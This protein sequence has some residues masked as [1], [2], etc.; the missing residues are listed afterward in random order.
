[1]GKIL[2]IRGGAIGDFILTLPVLSALRQ[3]FPAVRLELLTYPRVAGLAV[4]GRLVEHAQSIEARALASFFARRGTLPEHLGAYFESFGVIIS[5]LFD[6]D[7]IFEENVLRT[8]K[9]QFIAGPHR[10]DEAAGLH[11]TETFL[12]PLKRLA[13]FDADP[14][15]RL[16]LSSV[17]RA[18]EV[19]TAS[20]TQSLNGASDSLQQNPWLALHPGS[21]SESKNWPLEY[22]EMLI[23]RLLAETELHFLLIGGEA[24]SDRLEKLRKTIPEN[25]LKV[26]QSLPLPDL[27]YVLRQCGFY[28]G[29][30]SGI[31]HLA[32][33]L[34]VPG[35]VLWGPSRAEIWRPRSERFELLT[36]PEGLAG[37]TVDQVIAVL[38]QGGPGASR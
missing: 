20:T 31:T 21:G 10:P 27:A 35:L 9:A 13:I 37:I 7:R 19:T 14:V 8:T 11:A 18:S 17:P 32:A 24:E 15:P 29:H 4:A 6:P 25:R 33:A 34:G 38:R 22:W 16:E 36:S 28:L 30:D 5:Y 2:V 3:Q 23:R 26:A 1:M 12:Q